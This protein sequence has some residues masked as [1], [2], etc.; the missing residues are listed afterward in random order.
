[1]H[2]MPFPSPKMINEKNLELIC[3]VVDNEATKSEIREFEQL[4][5]ESSEAIELYIQMKNVSS[6]LSEIPE[7]DPPLM[8]KR[9]VMDAISGS[10]KQSSQIT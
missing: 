3:K 2:G 9:N 10:P 7:V 1:M 6:K 5:I 4:I 8:L